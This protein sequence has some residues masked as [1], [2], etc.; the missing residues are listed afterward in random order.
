MF[1]ISIDP[2]TLKILISHFLTR[3]YLNGLEGKIINLPYNSQE[4][5]DKKVLEWHYEQF[6]KLNK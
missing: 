1:F 5:P 4:Y 6:L 3:S 2:N